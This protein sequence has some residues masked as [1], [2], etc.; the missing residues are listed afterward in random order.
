M[1]EVHYR[2]G[3]IEDSYTVFCLFEE[4]LSDEFQ[5]FGFEATSWPDPEKL[6]RMWRQRASLYHHLAQTA[7]HFWI[8]ERDGRAIGF[9][10]SI[11]RDGV[12]Q[13]T[14][15]FVLPGDQSGGVGRELLARAFPAG[16]ARRRSIIATIDTRA[17]ARYLKSGVY[18]RFPLYYFYRQPEKI[19]VESDLAFERLNTDPAAETLATLGDIDEAIL[20]F[21]REE[22]HAWLLADRP[23]CLYRRNGRIAGYGYMGKANGPFALLDVADFPAVLAHAETQAAAEG[24]G[25]FGLEVPMVNQ[26]AVDY[27]ISRNFNIHGFVTLLMSDAP[28][29][30]FENYLALSPPFM[31]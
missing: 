7:E 2:P 13:L 29:G 22:D 4:T 8:A 5:R 27:L 16:G 18:S 23:G 9:A 14:E 25:H 3:T 28:F 15:F 6:A 20:G 30:R 12:R 24:F 17:Q 21:R 31:L 19:T 10:R 26:V 1:D 11:L